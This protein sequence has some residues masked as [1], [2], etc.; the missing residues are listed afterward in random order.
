MDGTFKQLIPDV[1]LPDP[2]DV[3]TQIKSYADFV[4][5]YLRIYIKKVLDDNYQGWDAATRKEMLDEIE[6]WKAKLNIKRTEDLVD[7]L[8]DIA[9]DI[10]GEFFSIAQDASSLG[11]S[12]YTFFSKNKWYPRFLTGAFYSVALFMIY[13]GFSS[14]SD[15][16]DTEKALLIVSTAGVAATAC[17]DLTVLAAMKALSKGI[18]NLAEA[19][20]VMVYTTSRFDF[21]RLIARDKP[22][23]TLAQMG[24]ESVSDSAKW[25]IRIARIGKVLLDGFAKILVGAAMGFSVYEIVMDIKT[26]DYYGLALDILI[27]LSDALFLLSMF[28]TLTAMC[29]ALPVIGVVAFIAGIVLSIV[30]IFVKKKKPDNPIVDYVDAYLVDFVK[31]LDNPPADWLEKHPMDKEE[32]DDDNDNVVIGTDLVFA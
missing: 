12:V 9:V 5:E 11:E 21:M 28:E 24:V 7:S 13:S 23:E 22:L 29:A 10:M 1:N 19:D 14:F 30:A 3:G 25:L 18:G 6:A 4:A 20:S 27:L 2:K 15:L 32:K 8:D 26:G 31:G 16:S 17:F